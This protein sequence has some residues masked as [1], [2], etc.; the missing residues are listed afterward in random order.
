MSNLCRDIEAAINRNSAEN[1]SNTPD[2]ILAH[3]LEATL[4]AFD[5]A[6]R[7]RDD[8]HGFEP[9]PT[10]VARAGPRHDQRAG[11]GRPWLSD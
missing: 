3:F 5:L 6:V 9:W 7:D 4:A 10:N 11:G 8:W 1:G 2:Y